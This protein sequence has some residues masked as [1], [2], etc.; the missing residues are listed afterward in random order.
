MSVTCSSA[1]SHLVEVAKQRNGD[2]AV[3]RG[4]TTMIVGPDA[5]VDSL[6]KRVWDNF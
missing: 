5:N 4:R 6:V 3:S 1:I 2:I